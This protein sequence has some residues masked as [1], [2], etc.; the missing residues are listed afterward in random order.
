M[1]R[2][3][4]LAVWLIVFAAVAVTSAG[5]QVGVVLSNGQRFSGALV[6]QRFDRIFLEIDG[7]QYSWVQGEIAVVEF[8]GGRP[9][10]RELSSLSSVPR[11]F[12]GGAGATVVLNNGQIMNGRFAGLGEGRTVALFTAG[13]RQ[14]IIPAGTV[15]RVYLN[16]AV[17]RDLYASNTIVD[18][19]PFVPP[20]P[21]VRPEDPRGPGRGVPGR[22]NNQD[23]G[24][25]AGTVTVRV[26][27]RQAWTPANLSVSRGERLAFQATGQIG[28]GRGATQVADPDGVNP[29]DR[30]NYPVPS[31]GAGA[32]VGR[33]DNGRPF[34]IGAS[35]N[36]IAMPGDGQLFLGVNDDDCRDNRGFF[37]VRIAQAQVRRR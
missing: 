1:S 22:G 4:A 17:A 18:S 6:A 2:S 15:A 19:V 12:E 33:V 13:G 29:G 16:A 3:R 10:Q 28:W 26:D 23:A 30:Q 34:F 5:P 20:P 21:P 31:A 24:N 7:R 32:L 25:F 35:T 8:A 11:Q 9:S 37:V 14:E 27:A 36:P